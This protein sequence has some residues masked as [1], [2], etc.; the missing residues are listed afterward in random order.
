MFEF[1]S[2]KSMSLADSDDTDF[3][4]ERAMLDGVSTEVQGNVDAN[5]RHDSKAP[6]T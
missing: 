2:S 6:N 3:V 4:T 1:L 5:S